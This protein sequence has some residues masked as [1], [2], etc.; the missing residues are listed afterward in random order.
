LSVSPRLT[1]GALAQRTGSSVPTVRYYEAI[2][3]L[4][5]PRRGA[6]GQRVY[7]EDDLKRLAFVR[8]CRDF[9]LPIETIRELVSLVDHPERDCSKAR[10]VAELQLTHLRHKL[11]ELKALEHGLSQL[12]T[13][14]TER[15]AGG[16]ARDCV[17]LADLSQ[18]D[19]VRDRCCR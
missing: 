3:L 18:Q 8:R 15:C 13:A 1:I 7:D 19:S 2:G 9:D 5:K 4:P 17:M 16:P 10:D 14:C 6:G 12:A 11:A